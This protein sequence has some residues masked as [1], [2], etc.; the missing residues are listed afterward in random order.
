[1]RKLTVLLVAACLLFAIPGSAGI[2]KQSAT[3]PSALGTCPT[4][5][6]STTHD[7]D[8]GLNERKNLRPDSPETQGAAQPMSLRAIKELPDPENFSMGDPRDEL[9]ALGEGTKVRVVAYLLRAKPE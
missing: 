5:G 3:C 8:G 6:C 4:D 2:K 9:A 7:V 1:M